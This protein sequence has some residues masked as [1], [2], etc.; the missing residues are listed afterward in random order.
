MTAEGLVDFYSNEV[1]S[2]FS[3]L[4]ATAF[5]AAIRG[6]SDSTIGQLFNRRREAQDSDPFGSSGSDDVS[7][8]KSYEDRR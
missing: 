5:V 1:V 6:Y 3:L 8:A 2:D 7:V 4:S